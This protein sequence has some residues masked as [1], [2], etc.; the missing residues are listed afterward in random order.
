[1][2]LAVDLPCFNTR[3]SLASPDLPRRYGSTPPNLTSITKTRSTSI[4]GVNGFIQVKKAVSKLNLS[5]SSSLHLLWEP[6]HHERRKAQGFQLWICESKRCFTSRPS[7]GNHALSSQREEWKSPNQSCNPIKITE[8]LKVFIIC[9]TAHKSLKAL[10]NF[11]AT[12]KDSLT[13]ITVLT[14]ENKIRK[15]INVNIRVSCSVKIRPLPSKQL[16]KQQI[17]IKTHPYPNQN[18]AFKS[19]TLVWQAILKFKSG[20][21]GK[22]TGTQAGNKVN[23]VTKWR[24]THTREWRRQHRDT[25]TRTRHL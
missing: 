23:S 3:L 4:L 14:E 20:S 2:L 12:I 18:H 5:S 19:S 9:V 15:I 1:M 8:K 21:R 24:R 11:L 16:G 13:T 25:S 10:T 17:H 7:T 6:H 22:V